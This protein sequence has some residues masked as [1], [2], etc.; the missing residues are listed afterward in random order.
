MMNDDMDKIQR[1]LVRLAIIVLV[2]GCTVG[3]CSYINKKIGLSDDHLL[4]ELLE[5]HIHEQTGISTDLT[6]ESPE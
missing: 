4:E 3:G 5:H 2:I 6:P 1:W